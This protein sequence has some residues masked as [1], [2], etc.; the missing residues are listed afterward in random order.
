MSFR[1]K[2][3]ADFVML[4]RLSIFL[5]ST[6]VMFGTAV[7]VMTKNE[8]LLKGH[9]SFNYFFPGTIVLTI[10]ALLVARYTH[11]TRLEFIHVETENT[12]DRLRQFKAIIFL[13]HSI[14]NIPCILSIICYALYGN[15]F[16]VLQIIIVMA[17]MIKKYPS[18]DRVNEAV[19]ILNFNSKR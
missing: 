12:S 5:M 14:C 18:E 11:R 3:K 8:H 15:F 16:F 19:T 7:V 9:D 17:E 6:V 13:H 10:A 1:P 2:Y 4:S